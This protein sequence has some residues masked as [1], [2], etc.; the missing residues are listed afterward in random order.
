VISVF[1]EGVRVLFLL[2]YRV[3]VRAPHVIK[4]PLHRPRP[5]PPLPIPLPPP[6]ASRRP[7]S[8]APVGRT[9]N[10]SLAVRAPSAPAP[11]SRPEPTPPG[12]NEVTPRSACPVHPPALSP[13]LLSIATVFLSQ[14]ARLDRGV[15]RAILPI[16]RATRRNYKVK[17]RYFSPPRAA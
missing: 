14:F 4:R 2:I 5:F 6:P 7:S 15:V 12:T 3:R 1:H 11:S 16:W 17:V 8:S 10:S 9:A 13:P